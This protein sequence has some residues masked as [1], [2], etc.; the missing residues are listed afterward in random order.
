[1]GVSISVGKSDLNLVQKTLLKLSKTYNSRVQQEVAKSA[2]R[3]ES[4]AKQLVRV[5]LG[6]LRSSIAPSYASD[7]LTASVGT[8][9]EYALAQEFGDPSKPSYG[10]TPYLGPAYRAEKPRFLA[11][12]R[13]AMIP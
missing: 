8:N 10:Y 6:R 5:D 3:I 4:T 7:G 9:V 11:N 12:I 13:K 1:M 2:L